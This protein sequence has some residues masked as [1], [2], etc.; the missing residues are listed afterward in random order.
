MRCQRKEDRHT[1]RATTGSLA[2]VSAGREVEVQP[3]TLWIS[4]PIP[5]FY[6][7]TQFLPS[8]RAETLSPRATPPV[9]E[10]QQNLDVVLA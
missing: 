8:R 6:G 10:I 5:L 2:A 3:L 9:S 1:S 4:L 7:L